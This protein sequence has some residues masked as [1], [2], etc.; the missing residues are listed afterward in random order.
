MKGR[1]AWGKELGD[2]WQMAAGSWQ[3]GLTRRGGDAERRREKRERQRAERQDA[4]YR[5]QGLN[6]EF[7]IA[8]LKT[9][10]QES[11]DRRT[12]GRKNLGFRIANCEFGGAEGIESGHRVQGARHKVEET[13]VRRQERLSNLKL[14]T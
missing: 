10:S 2:S 9:R 8:D 4:G 3:S 12:E 13:G 7:R 11:G 6:C 14:G 1:G 5:M